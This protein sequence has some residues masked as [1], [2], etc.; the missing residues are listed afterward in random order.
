M[1]CIFCEIAA[2]VAPASRV[3]EDDRCVAFMDIHPLGDGHVLVI[4]RQHAEQITEIDP[5]LS[6]HLFKVAQSV[7]RAQRDNG[8]GLKG[9]HILLNDGKAANQQVPHIHVHIIPRHRGDAL[10]SF[11]RL[12]L[13][14]TGVFGRAQSRGTLEAQ[15][16]QLRQALMPEPQAHTKR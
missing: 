11:G 8:L 13:H 15:A 1:R 2:G 16:E 4:P 3:Y 12:V 6:L 10:R 14:V 5:D 7:L 9:S